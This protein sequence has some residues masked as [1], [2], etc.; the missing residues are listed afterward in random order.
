MFCLSKTLLAYPATAMHFLRQRSLGIGLFALLCALTVG[1]AGFGGNAQSPTP[2]A[3]PQSV[4]AV[5]NLTASVDGQET[6]AVRLT[7]SEAENAQ[8]HFVVYVKSAELS[9]GNYGSARMV[10]FAGSQG[11]VSGLEGGTSYSFIVIGMRWNWV[12]YG[13]VWGSWSAWV[14]ATPGGSASSTS[15]APAAEPKSVSSV[16]NLSVSTD[17]Q[18]AGA[19][20]L[21]WSEA[22]NAQVHFVVYVKSAELSAGNYGS[23]RMVPFAGSQGVV[24]GL[25]G[26]TSYRFIVIGMRWN[27]V[28]YGTVWGAWSDWTTAIRAAAATPPTT[29]TT[30]LA[31]GSIL[32]P[33]ANLR[34]ALER[35]LSKMTGVPIYPSEMAT[36]E[37]IVARFSGVRSLEGL[38]HATNSTA[39]ILNN[40]SISDLSPLSGLSRL[41]TLQLSQNDISDLS[42]LAGLSNLITLRLDGNDISD[43]APLVANE[44]LTHGVQ[45]DVTSNPLSSA[46][47]NEDIPALQARGIDISYDEIVFTADDEPQ[48]YNGNVFVFPVAENLA[49]DDLAISDYVARFYQ[50]FEDEFDF[51]FLISNLD[52]REDEARR[53]SGAYIGFR[54]DVPGIGTRIYSYN[55]RLGA[56]EQLQAAVHFTY[57][58]AVR[59]G[60]SLHE[61]MH[62]WANRVIPSSDAVHWGFSSA[63][64][65]LGG[66]DLN[67]LVRHGDGRYTAGEFWPNANGGNIVPYSPIELYLAG[68]IPPEEASGLWVAEDG[69]FLRDKDGNHVK[70]DNGY[71]IFTATRV[72]TYT[73]EDIIA[74][75]GQRLPN[76]SQ[77]QHEFRAAAVLLIDE[78]HPASRRAL[79]AVSADV[80]WLSHPGADTSE[81]YNFYEATGGRGI[82]AMEGLSQFQK[83]S[84]P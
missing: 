8:V 5:A 45:I 84:T 73:I 34:A 44:A 56:G 46:S 82:F 54:N 64:G 24:S 69:Q 58:R 52:Y 2:A 42:P 16:A 18:Q 76:A 33:D 27:W 65:Q 57:Y 30:P 50:D 51:V 79:E 74:E 59:N 62:Q 35:H 38:Q 70:A 19:V 60:P 78:A 75:H 68:F 6:G 66:F 29:T 37:Y 53:Y 63:N 31:D 71:R 55:G 72:R 1:W 67:D 3:E 10:P 22:E 15:T 61:L 77:A 13:T 28:E 12:D 26:G 20:R 48:I 83:T 9:A 43:L 80:S 40:N 81:L 17:G 14:S 11:V 39:L 36:L 21:T 4:G 47:I 25:E 32:I 41:R 49:K 7:W 23:A